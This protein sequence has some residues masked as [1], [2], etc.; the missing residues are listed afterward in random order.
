MGEVWCLWEGR[1]LSFFPYR[2]GGGVPGSGLLAICPVL[3]RTA[4]NLEV[5]EVI[6]R[7]K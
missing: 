6:R 5:P 4:E 7:D 2:P 3:S 1:S